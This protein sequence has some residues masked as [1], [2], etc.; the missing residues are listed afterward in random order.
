MKNSA[1]PTE[2]L[3]QKPGKP[4]TRTRTKPGQH[5][6]FVAVSDAHHELL[7]KSADGRPINVWLSK[8][9]E[10]HIKEWTEV[11]K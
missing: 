7:T 1:A 4:I 3:D 9:I 5:G 10:R 8:L 2:A 11:T 6:L